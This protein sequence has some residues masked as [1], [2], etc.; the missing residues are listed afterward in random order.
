M[1]RNSKTLPSEAKFLYDIKNNKVVKVASIGEFDQVI[2]PE[3]GNFKGVFAIDKKPYTVEVDWTFNERNDI[4]WIDATTGKSTK[5]L[6]GVF[7]TPSWNPQGTFAVMYDEKQK[8]W[9]VFDSSSMQFKNA[10]A[11]IAFPV[12]DDN[13]DMASANTAYGFA[14]WLNNGN[15]LVIYDQFDMWALDLTNQ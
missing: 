5:I 3:S 8:S 7:G 1:Q 15:T 12:S 10:G 9:M 4:F 6:T 13:V 14:G 11:Q 2:I